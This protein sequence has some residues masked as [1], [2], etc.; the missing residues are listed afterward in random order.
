MF[1]KVNMLEGK[2]VPGMLAVTMPIM[3]LSVINSV[4]NL[5]DMTVLKQFGAGDAVGAVG[6]CGTLITLLSVLFTGTATGASV[7]VARY[8]G[9]NDK[10]KVQ[11]AVGTAMLVA[12]VGGIVLMIVGVIGSRTFLEWMDTPVELIDDSTL[13][14]RLYFLGFPILMLYTF[15]IPMLRAAGYTLQP[16]IFSL[17]GGVLKVVLTFVFV[18]FC[19]MTIEGV[20]LATIASWITM[21]VLSVTTIIK[22]NTIVKLN[23][24]CLR[25]YGTELKEMFYIGIPTGLQQGL[26][27]F[28][29]V[30]IATA[31]NSFGPN[32]TTGIS[33]ANTFDGI[34]YSIV[35]APATAVTYYVSQNVGK[36]NV[37]RAEQSI[38]RGMLITL[39]F[40]A[41]LGSLSA[42]LSPQLS[43]IMSDVPEVIQYSCQKMRIISSTY[44]ICG[45]NE[46][47]C[48]TM[49]G[50]RKPI[51]PTVSTLL[52]MCAIRFPWVYFIFPLVPNLT[53]LYLIWPIGWVLSI[54]TIL[55]FYFPAMKKLKRKNALT[56]LGLKKA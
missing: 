13:Y 49:R 56:E 8:I 5:I 22:T 44:F 46:I 11:R 29:N 37:K 4:F 38:L 21:A 1:K 23:F 10:E 3:L 48:A 33:I 31:V 51:V 50:I 12:L 19:D 25:F 28:A 18:A 6:A 15:S 55:C 2:I 39:A 16:M 43:S 17:S 32:A 26:Y 7:T 35:I 53:F 47:L 54:S 36:G 30:V 34:M 24:K 14:F 52:F 45:I 40:G 42:I 27:S 41:T 9:K 20:A